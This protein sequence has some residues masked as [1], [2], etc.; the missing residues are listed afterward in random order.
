M[1]LSGQLSSFSLSDIFQILDR[2]KKTGRLKLQVSA[3]ELKG[4]F[5][6]YLWFNQGRIVTLSSRLDHAEFLTMIKR[7][8]W[9]DNET[10][11]Q[12]NQLRILEMPLGK[13]LEN[14]GVLQIGHLK[15]LFHAQVVQRICGL[16]KF[17]EG[18]FQF[19]LHIPAPK[20][21]MTGLS[22]S[23]VE[24]TLLGFRALKDWRS[25]E[26]RLPNLHS[27]LSKSLVTHL[28][29]QL[30]PLER[31][32][33][34][35]SN[36]TLSLLEIADQL[37]QPPECIQRTAFRLAVIGLVEEL[38]LNSSVP[39]LDLVENL[40]TMTVKEADADKTVSPSFLQNLLGFLR[41]NT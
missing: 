6:Y 17:S 8:R 5:C 11:S 14:Q 33:W 32:V 40:P 28:S 4:T 9:I 26:N 21:E 3:E 18:H 41:S 35:L 27:A 15:L 39:K 19:D 20:A 24:A 2:G 31:K 16:F 30:D 1:A 37:S 36:G 12:L 23:T 7:R 25:L 38:P 22:I 10:I 29:I 34:D 13:Y